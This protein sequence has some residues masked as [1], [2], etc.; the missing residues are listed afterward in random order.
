MNDEPDKPESSTGSM[1]L[2]GILYWVV[3]TIFYFGRKVLTL[4][5]LDYKR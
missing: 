3:D 5:G 2:A 1:L 4:R